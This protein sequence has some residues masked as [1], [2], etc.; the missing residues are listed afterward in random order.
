MQTTEEGNQEHTINREGATPSRVIARDPDAP[1]TVC[2]ATSAA[3]RSKNVLT[4][5]PVALHVRL[6]WQ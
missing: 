6:C 2:C 3:A 4:T 1:D 5:K